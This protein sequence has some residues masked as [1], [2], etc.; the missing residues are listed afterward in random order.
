MLEEVQLSLYPFELKCCNLFALFVT[1]LVQ[2][3]SW[4]VSVW[5]M[6]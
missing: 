4:V 1:A 3:R 6:L 2:G 5:L